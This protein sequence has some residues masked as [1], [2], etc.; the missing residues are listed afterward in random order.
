MAGEPD[1]STA[2]VADPAIAESQPETDPRD[3][4]LAELRERDAA[5]LFE[6]FPHLREHLDHEIESAI[7]ERMPLIEQDVE[8]R[9]RTRQEESLLRRLRDTDPIAFA[10][11]SK[12]IEAERLS[13]AAGRPAGGIDSL[14]TVAAAWAEQL[15]TE[16][17]AA[18]AKKYYPQTTEG[19]NRYVKDV[20]ELIRVRE[21]ERA[22]SEYEQKAGPALKKEAN[23]QTRGRN[24]DT[25]APSAPP[26]GEMSYADLRS[27]SYGE[28]QQFR[29]EHPAE[30][31][32]LVSQH[33]TAGSR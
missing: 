6:Q 17:Q 5:E 20:Q 14:V 12:R 2:V 11:E 22:I 10:Q 3:Q 32:R 1:I 23:A 27:R 29:R 8:E 15:S 24:P 7:S 33:V 18:L 19:L 31:N 21:R 28:I 16:D 26:R 9:I 25:G 4:I 30:Y 13:R